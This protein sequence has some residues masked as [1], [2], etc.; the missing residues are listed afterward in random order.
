[1]GL[2]PRDV[3]K[4]GR[5]VYERHRAQYEQRHRGKYVLIDVRSERIYLADSPEAAYRQAVARHESGPFHVMRVGD[6]AAYRSR[7]LHGVATRVTR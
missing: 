4:A 2:N 6:R 5:K 7:S 1:M 3:A